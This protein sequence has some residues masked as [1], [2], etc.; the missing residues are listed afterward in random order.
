MTARAHS[1]RRRYASGP[2][3]LALLLLVPAGAQAQDAT[4]TSTAGA[5]LMKGAVEDAEPG[6]PGSVISL[7]EYQPLPPPTAADVE[8]PQ[9]FEDQL[10]RLEQELIYYRAGT[11]SFDEDMRGLIRLKYDEQKELLAAQY[12]RA[13]DELEEK[14][15]SRRLE[16]IARFEEFLKKYPNDPIYTPDAMFRLAELYYEKSSD[17][18]LTRSRGY[19]AELAA[20]EAGERESEPPPPEPSFEKTI[21]LHRDL[22]ARFPDYRLA[23]AARYL[24]GYC[25]GEQG[26]TEEALAAYLELTE[27]HPD[28]KF[29]AEVWTRIGEIYFDGNSTEALEKAIAAYQKVRQYPDSP[30]YDKALYK[31]AWT[32]Y[33]LDRY[34]EAVASF[35][36]LVDYADEQKRLTGTSGSE[37][38][39][40]AIQYIAISLA[41]DQWGGL[42]KAKAVLGPIESKEYTGEL[43]KRYG[44][45]LYDQTRYAQAIEVLRF[46]LKKY[47]NAP[48][49][50]EAQAKIVTAYEQLRD[51]D[52]ATAARE[53]LV[54]NYS[55]GS[56]WYEANK[57]DREAI[58]AAESLTERS[59]Y[60]AAIFRHQQ[61][62]AHKQA[63][64]LA[65]A[66]EQY[67][68]AADAYKKY[69]DRFPQSKNAYDFQFFLAECL[70]YS[71]DYLAAAKQYDAVR[72]SQL[73]NKHL[74]AAA[75]SSVISYEKEVENEVKAGKL[76][77]YPVLTAAQRKS[78]TLEPKEIAPVRKE[79]IASSD[80]FA[81]IL[82][83]SERAPAVRYR[84]A[85]IFYRHDQLDEARRRFEQV[86][87]DYPASDVARYAS[88]LII[89]SYLAVQDW[90]NVEKWSQ[91]LIE[92]AQGTGVKEG[93]QKAKD[94]F[95]DSLK[96]FKVGALF[97]QAEEYDAAGKFEEAADTYVKLVDENPKHE[98]ADKALFNAAVAYEKV[99]RFD[100]ASRIYQRIFDEYPSSDLAPRSL[101]RVGINAEKGFDFPQAVSAYER[102]VNKYP[103]SENRADALYNMAVVLE[104]QQDYA[105][106]AEAFK[107]YATT[108]PSRDD[109]GENYF[110]AALVYEK[111]SAWNDMVATLGDYIKKFDRVSSQ[112]ERIIEAHKKIGD[113]QMAQ[114]KETLAQRAYKACVDQFKAKKLS[115]SSKAARDAAECQFQI[116]EK[117]FRDYDE[118]KIEGSGK[119]QVAALTAKAKAQRSVEQA[120][121]DVFQYKRVEQTL[122]ASYR[123]GYSYERF[124]ESLFAAP[125]PKEFEN[126][127]EYAMEY[128][129]QLEDRAAVL[130][131]KAETAYRKAYEEAKRTRVTNEWTELILEG[132]NKYAPNEFP[133]QKRG[134]PMLQTTTISG[135]G[136]DDL[137]AA[138]A[139]PAPAG[140][141]NGAEPGSARTANANGE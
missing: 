123:I 98:F 121:T 116:A 111:M 9:S 52:G 65:Q 122:A 27:K 5:A 75:L 12:D 59:L 36:E 99:K 31:I 2:L 126:N 42:E 70:Y 115:V 113:A 29:L 120:Y 57:D 35:I 14:E 77:D 79:L 63:G 53:E 67:L 43:W 83:K 39:A 91:R 38:R 56:P 23:D 50:P 137:G 102:L 103:N 61:A 72:D 60:T 68:A 125:I 85:E 100:T 138:P 131:R 45:I 18:Y 48:Y 22:L 89:E 16:A 96:T 44:E 109:A 24:L 19:E 90:E 135:Y 81:A 25:Y 4:Q 112:K 130:E 108:F 129:A 93:D 69:L 46:T 10:K 107:R 106:A 74:E 30:Y 64:R 87:A 128:R 28:S 104:N 32:Y 41:D 13:I 78:A 117:T 66:K 34:D 124:A 134:K 17:E 11:E 54:Q 119:K 58:T 7:E 1:T 20:Y 33:R 84:A 8:N 21:G 94:E 141:Q 73:D 127:E 133:I 140:A 114:N 76:P 80:R 6:K 110:R 139:A 82:P 136:L 92:V 101:F 26:Q 71:D 51:F 47:P 105:K 132:L 3:G 62:Q 49:N 55:E 95:I 86:V 118:L 40:E 88:N 37:L 97:K 15:R